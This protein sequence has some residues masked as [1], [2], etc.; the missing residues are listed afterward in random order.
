MLLQIKACYSLSD[1]NQFILVLTPDI[2][3]KYDIFGS[4]MQ[5]LCLF[6]LQQVMIEFWIN[7]FLLIFEVLNTK[8]AQKQSW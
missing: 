8:C 6:V 2:Q 1:F 3:I 5:P 4:Q 7:A